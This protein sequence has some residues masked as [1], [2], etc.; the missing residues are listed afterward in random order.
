MKKANEKKNKSEKIK[1]TANDATDANQPEDMGAVRQRISKI[2]TGAA[3]NIAKKL[4][5]KAED[6]ELAHSKYLF[7]MAGVYPMQ[8]AGGKPPEEES[9]AKTLLQRMGLPT[10]PV[11]EDENGDAHELAAPA[12]SKEPQEPAAADE[13]GGKPAGVEADTKQLGISRQE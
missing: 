13:D 11:I 4:V 1:R 5:N 2:V 6:G 8:D 10:T 3:E 7:E 9:L 12:L